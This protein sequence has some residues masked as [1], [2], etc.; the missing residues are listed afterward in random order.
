MKHETGASELHFAILSVSRRLDASGS[1]SASCVPG[2]RSVSNG[3]ARLHLHA[4]ES[5]RQG[6]KWLAWTMVMVSQE[7]QID[8]AGGRITMLASD[9]GRIWVSFIRA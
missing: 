1:R 4:S 3:V 9:E 5:Q 8:G 2:D 7:L 6:M